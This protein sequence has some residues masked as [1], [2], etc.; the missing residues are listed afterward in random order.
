MRRWCCCP[1]TISP[2]RSWPRT[3]PSRPGLTGGLW[4]FL[5]QRWRRECRKLPRLCRIPD[6]PPVSTGGSRP[7]CRARASTGPAWTAPVWTTC[8]GGKRPDEGPAGG[9]AG[10]LSRPGAGRQPRSRPRADR[11]ARAPRG[12]LPA[13]V[14]HE[15]E[16]S[17]R[18][19]RRRV[20]AGRERGGRGAERHRL[21][22]LHAGPA[23][24]RLAAER[25]GSARAPG[26][27]LRRQREGL[28]RRDAGTLRPGHRHERGIARGRRADPL[29]RGLLQ[30]RGPLRR[31]HAVPAGRLR[32]GARPGRVR[33]EA[34]RALAA[35]GPHAG[36][37]A[38]PRDRP[39]QLPEPRRPNRQRGRTG[40]PRQRGRAAAH[41]RS[42][43][44]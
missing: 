4:Y 10:L 3:P 31:V 35:A 6:R 19:R 20:A 9:G 39:R 13:A 43:G 15:P 14:L 44:L 22:R 27:V 2:T 40:Y 28:A 24:G 26:S 5:L 25:H 7:S 21:R 37:T 32:A 18:G 23:D 36:R 38:P 12:R 42:G 29:P 1:A 33:R 8:E 17:G 30:G 16:G 11:R 34:R 41:A